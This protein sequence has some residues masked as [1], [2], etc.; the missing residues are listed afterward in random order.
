MTIN[1]SE[2]DKRTQVNIHLLVFYQGGY[3]IGLHLRTYRKEK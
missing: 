2:K 3:N 1:K